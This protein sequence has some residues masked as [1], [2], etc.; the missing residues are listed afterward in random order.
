M[1][2]A[3]EMQGEKTGGEAAPVGSSWIFGTCDLCG[4][5]GGKDILALPHA[6][7]PAGLAFIRQ[8][9]GCGLRRLWPRPGDDIISR[10]YASD[11]GAYVGRRRSPLKQGLWDLLR[12]GASGAPGRAAIFA[13]LAACHAEAGGPGL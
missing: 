3:R 10:Y 7:A 12:D 5:S 9:R 13:P 8:C 11:Y 4:E 2:L 1:T 6:D